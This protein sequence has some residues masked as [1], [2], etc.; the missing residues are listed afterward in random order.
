MAAIAAIV[1]AIALIFWSTSASMVSVWNA[2]GTYSHGYFIVPAFLWLVWG[3]RQVLSRL[4]IAPAWW[5]LLPLAIV[6]GVWLVG[7]WMVL[8][9]PAQFAMVTMVP[10]AIAS[11]LG[12]AWVR[13]LAFPLA[14]LFF[15]VP[16]GESWVPVLMNW[17][18]DFT[19]AALKLSGVP[20]YR[21]GLHFEIPNGRWSVVDSCS[22]IRYLFAC[23]SVSSLYAWTIY[24]GRLRRLTFVGLALLIAIVANW[25]RAYIIV[26]LGHLSNNQ[27]A[28]GADH[29][30][31]GALFFGVIMALVFALG[32]LWR[33]DRAPSRPAAIS[34]V[35]P[36]PTPLLASTPQRVMA[37]L[38]TALVLLAAPLLSSGAS[39]EPRRLSIVP[40][41]IRSS[42]GWL[43]VGEPVASWQPRLNNPVALIA[44]S[45]EKDSRRVGVH[46]GLFERPTLDSKLTS[47]RN[48]LL[49]PDGLNPQ[50]KLAGQ[51]FAQA[52]WAGDTV[53]V[54]TGVL[55]GGERRLLAWHWYWVDGVATTSPTRAALLQILARLRGRSEVS[56]WVSAYTV[57][58]DEPSAATRA[59]EEFVADMS[60]SIDQTLASA[61]PAAPRQALSAEST[62]PR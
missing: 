28:T 52:R 23:L 8:A 62:T 19:V 15:A 30:V 16:F 3:R 61:L 26:M 47:A 36:L 24:R 6:V 51:G 56:A 45:F 41:D 17:T 46:L 10:L 9:Q 32:A 18:A 34:S 5:A 48:R 60:T 57:V 54:R 53:D 35:R 43:P 13:A 25:L 55:I 40:S 39:H 50:W 29:L 14:F 31:Y 27:I 44:Q 12:V 58:G 2:S 11:V 38:G 42:G 4:P 1:G 21:D 49:E 33:E 37:A 7:Q 22:G 20:V 59:L